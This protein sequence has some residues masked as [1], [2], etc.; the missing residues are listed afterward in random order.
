MSK[1]RNLSLK[2]KKPT[3]FGNELLVKTVDCSDIM[4]DIKGTR[5]NFPATTIQPVKTNFDLIV[6]NR[7]TWIC[8]IQ[9]E[10]A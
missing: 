5:L 9:L 2:V 1:K 3:D 10:K 8:I 6:L 4:S 7:M